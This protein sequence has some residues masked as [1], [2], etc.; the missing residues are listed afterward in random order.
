MNTPPHADLSVLEVL[1]SGTI[2]LE[3]QFVWGSNST[4]LVKVGSGSDEIAAVYKPARGERPLWDFPAGTLAKREVAAYLA[5]QVLGWDLIPPTLLRSDG[6]AGPGSLQF[7]VDV[8]PERHYFAFSDTERQQLRPVALFD[9]VVNNADRKGGHVL[10]DL[11]DHLWLIDHGVCFHPEF[12]LRTVVWDFAGEAI[13]A[14]L[15]SDVQRCRDDLSGET[16]L[17]SSLRGLLS[18]EEVLAMRARAEW[19]L[20]QR[21]FP[22]PGPGRPYPWPLV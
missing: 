1:R 2:R 7:Y 17:S 11:Q 5:S 4:F 20:N 12:K 10:L 22:H 3:G 6:P 13:P 9:I 18:P 14:A 21:H 15:L 8:D 16:E 19:L